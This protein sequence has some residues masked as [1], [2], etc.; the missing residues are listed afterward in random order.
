MKI[1]DPIRYLSWFPCTHIIQVAHVIHEIHDKW[2]RIAATRAIEAGIASWM[3]HKLNGLFTFNDAPC[4]FRNWAPN[5]NFDALFVSFERIDGKSNCDNC[6]IVTPNHKFHFISKRIGTLHPLMV[7]D[8][9]K[10]IKDVF[11]RD[12]NN[13]HFKFLSTEKD[14][15]PLLRYNKSII[16]KKIKSPVKIKRLKQIIEETNGEDRANKLHMDAEKKSSG[17]GVEVSWT[18]KLSTNGEI[19]GINYEHF[20]SW[21]KAAKFGKWN[22]NHTGTSLKKVKE[23]R[24]KNGN[25]FVPVKKGRCII[26]SYGLGFLICLDGFVY[27]NMVGKSNG[28]SQCLEITTSRPRPNVFCPPIPSINAPRVRGDHRDWHPQH[29]HECVIPNLDSLVCAPL[30]S[31]GQLPSFEATEGS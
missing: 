21:K 26:P 2:N 30:L 8:N 4:G 22:Y 24:D 15:I 27:Y 17:T 29:H 7:H 18:G 10:H 25:Y 5:T 1:N 3:T 31:G 11:G 12:N 28:E 6:C 19:C 14:E 23:N 9:R 13:F 20:M 16:I